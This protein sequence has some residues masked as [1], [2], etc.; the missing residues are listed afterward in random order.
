MIRIITGTAKNKKLK[1]PDVDGYRAVQE[2]AK[3]ALF[4]IFNDKVLDANCLDLYAGSGNLGIE[5][6]SRGAK[7]CD[8]V[9][10]NAVATKI[11]QEN[12]NNCGLNEKAEV[13]L[14]D[15]VKYVA[16]TDEK[17][18]LIFVDPFYS[19]THH[20]FLMKNLEEILVF[21]GIIAFFHG[22]ELDINK[23]TKETDLVATDIRRFGKSYFTLLEHSNK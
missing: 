17:Y 21:D 4:S 3:G 11:I 6:L 14:R 2:I 22:K 1:V 7:H 8:F 16:N 19:E 13:F 10:K 5:A 15:A 12:I 20:V 23:V 18:D 9:D